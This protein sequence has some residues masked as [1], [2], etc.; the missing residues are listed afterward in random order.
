M[1]ELH[2]TTSYTVLPPVP[3]P[4][5]SVFFQLGALQIWMPTP[6]ATAATTKQ[7]GP[8]KVA[9]ETSL[10]RLNSQQNYGQDF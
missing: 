9:W 10:N 7:E 6:G 8:L 2:K 5:D 1:T 4:T 3:H